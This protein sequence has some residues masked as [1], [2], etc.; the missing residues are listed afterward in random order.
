MKQ[1]K[2]RTSTWRALGIALVPL[3]IFCACSVDTT[4]EE[5]SGESDWISGADAAATAA[6]ATNAAP[7]AA[8]SRLRRVR[9]LQLE[10]EHRAL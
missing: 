8:S 2:H 6:K 5:G 7:E 3:T 4:D 1:G 10:R 9:D